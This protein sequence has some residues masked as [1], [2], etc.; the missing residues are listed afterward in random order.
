MASE[1]LYQTAALIDQ[2][3]HDDINVRVN[4]SSQLVR[5]ANA[6]GPERTRKRADSIFGRDDG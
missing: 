3:K 4:S 6:L 2:L 5:I 1:D